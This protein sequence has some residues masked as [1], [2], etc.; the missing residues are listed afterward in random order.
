MGKVYMR[1]QT[2]TA[3]KPYP[4]GTH[5]LS[6]YKGVPAPTPPPPHPPRAEKAQSASPFFLV[7]TRLSDSRNVARTRSRE[8]RTLVQ[9]EQA[10]ILLRDCCAQG[11]LLSTTYRTNPPSYADS[12]TGILPVE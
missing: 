7:F 3:Q 5:M 1:F 4:M 8:N 9:V 11:R 10:T 12:E 2:K 6:G